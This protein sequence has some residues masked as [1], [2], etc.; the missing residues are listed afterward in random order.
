MGVLGGGQLGRML[1]EAASPLAIRVAVLDAEPEAPSSLIAYKHQVGAFR[2]PEAVLD[3]AKK[4]DVITMEI[5]HVNVDA[6]FEL[7]A[8]G[9]E[10][11]PKA[12]T[13]AV[14]QDK[15]LQKVHFT[16]HGVPL[17][18]FRPVEDM[19][20]AHA[21][22]EEFGLPLMLKSR[23][24]AYDGKGN[25]VVRS[26][27]DLEDAVQALGGFDR[28]LY[29]EKWAPFVKELAVMVTRGRD[30][31]LRSFPLVETTHK[32]NICHTVVAPAPGV[33]EA[34]QERAKEVAEL[35]IGSLAG[36]GVFGV[37][38]FLLPNDEVLLNEV[39]PRPHNSGHYTIEGCNVSQYEQHLRAVLG[40]PLG[41][42]SLKVGAAAMYNILGEADDEEGFEMA[43]AVLQR[44]LRVPGASAHWYDKAEMK[45]GRKMGHVTVVGDSMEDAQARLKAVMGTAPIPMQPQKLLRSFSSNGVAAAAA[46]AAAAAQVGTA[47]VAIIMGSDSDLPV[48]KAAAQIL[49][50]FGVTYELTVVSAH[51]TPVRMLRFAQEAHKRGIKVIIAGAGGA[52]HLPGMVAS[53]S[54]L[55]VIGVPV[56]GS[57]TDGMDSLLSIVQMPRGIPVA[58]VAINNAANAGLL[59]VRMLAPSSPEL[60]EKMLAYQDE[61]EAMVLEKAEKLE[62]NGWESYLRTM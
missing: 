15:Y 6:L 17:P 36:A 24:N 49:D 51:R 61:L 57:S 58:T 37:E 41:D 56:K 4:C 2:D 32:D 48:M 59:A 34:I 27:E 46:P 13:I 50:S 33:P 10:V 18:D 14:I 42:T 47:D 38:L 1:C 9:I 11:E 8:A 22:M 30:G 53:M 16:N 52:A 54:P 28:G 7:E 19:E 21:V 3:F 23:K 29:A 44:T 5:E 39:A 25:A 62:S 26:P 45:K 40:L 35:A 20:A 60:L 12:S 43:S 31:E 55:P